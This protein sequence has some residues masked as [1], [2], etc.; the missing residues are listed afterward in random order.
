MQ[1][2]DWNPARPQVRT[3]FLSGVDVCSRTGEGTSY[4]E[5]AIGPVPDKE[6]H[7]VSASTHDVPLASHQ[8]DSGLIPE[9]PCVDLHCHTL[10]EV[11]PSSP[12]RPERGE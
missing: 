12:Y 11:H 8:L 6:I 3:S 10:A 4:A 7:P 1:L 2:T 9:V 5:I